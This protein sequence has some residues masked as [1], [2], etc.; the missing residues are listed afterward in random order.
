MNPA[1]WLKSLFGDPEDKIVLEPNQ[2][3]HFELRHE[4]HYERR[5]NLA[6]ALAEQIWREQ[7]LVSTRMGWNFTFQ[8]FL[9]AIYTFAGTGFA[10]YPAF[11]TRLV[12]ALVGFLV[13]NF[14]LEGVRAAQR[15]SSRLK[16]HWHCEFTNHYAPRDHRDVN[17]CRGA[18]PQPFSSR[19]GSSQGR[20][21]SNNMCRLMMW[22][23]VLMTIITV[24]ALS[25][26]P[27]FDPQGW[28]SD[29]R[30]ECKATDITDVPVKL[31]CTYD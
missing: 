15:Q 3:H 8:G 10:P 13:A 19:Q 30:L 31:S 7:Q 29:R 16:A 1:R 25:R 17:V 26:P 14:T 2:P 4:R 21:A 27:A 28:S 12:L 20:S 11:A 18:F 24:V 23:W 22:M 6:N 9:A 5:L